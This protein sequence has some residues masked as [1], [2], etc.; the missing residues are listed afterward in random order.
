MEQCILTAQCSQ[1]VLDD[2]L[3]NYKINNAF[4]DHK[5]NTILIKKF[6]F[7]QNF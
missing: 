5:Y 6:N 2:Y 7:N 4:V 1:T 3:L